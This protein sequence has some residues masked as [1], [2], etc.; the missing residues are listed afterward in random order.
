M[1]RREATFS[2]FKAG[3]GSFYGGQI[4]TDSHNELELHPFYDNRCL[5]LHLHD[6]CRFENNNL[7][8]FG[9]LLFGD[10]SINPNNN[11]ITFPQAF[12][13]KLA[14]VR[15]VQVPH[16]GSSKNWNLAE[17]ESLNIGKNNFFVAVCNFGYGNKFGHPSHQVLE[18]LSSKIF[19]NTQF[20]R[21]NIQYL[22]ITHRP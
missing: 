14:N 9:T 5:S 1:R 21:L 17:F 22:N 12:K 18:D 7:I 6:D 16:H 10:T 2:F 13:D 20:S 3:Q 11:P 19:L 4:R 8:M 15:I